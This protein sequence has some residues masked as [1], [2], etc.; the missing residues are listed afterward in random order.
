MAESFRIK[1]KGGGNDLFLT[2][3]SGKVFFGKEYSF[4]WEKFLK[5]EFSPLFKMYVLL[6]SDRF[7]LTQTITFDHG[8]FKKKKYTT[9]KLTLRR[10]QS[11]C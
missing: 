5:I 1:F 11:L 2:F 7:N 4:F 10:I 6:G 3:F 8:T 9:G